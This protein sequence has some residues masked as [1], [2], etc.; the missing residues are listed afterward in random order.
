VADPTTTTDDP[1][2]SAPSHPSDVGTLGKYRV[3][4]L[5]GKGGMGAV[6]LGY[7]PALERK[8]ALKVML[9]S[10]AARPAARERF[11]REARAAAK[12][13]S[14]FVAP[15]YEVG[16]DGGSPFLAMEYL[17]GRS[18]DEYLREAGRPTIP[19]AVRIARE[20]A[21]GLAAAHDIGM[22]HRDVKP[23]NLWLEAPKG[24]VKLLDFGLVRL[25]QDDA[26]LTSDGQAV[27]TPAFMSPEQARGEKVDLRTDLYSLG[28][29]LYLMLTGRLPFPGTTAFETVVRLTTEDAPPVRSLNPQVPE[30]LAELVHRLLF[31]NPVARPKS[32]REVIAA[33]K[34]TDAPL[35][36][37]VQTE[38]PF[39]GIDEQTETKSAMPG[40]PVLPA[41]SRSPRWWLVTG[42]VIG[43]VTIVGGGVLVWRATRPDSNARRPADSI[44]LVRTDAAA[45]DPGKE[46]PATTPAPGADMPFFN[47]K[48]LAGWT[49]EGPNGWKV[50][51]GQLI[52][53]WP[54]G[55]NRDQMLRLRS[56]RTYRDFEL[57]F[58]FRTHARDGKK[59]TWYGFP[60]VAVR[61]RPAASA[62]DQP[63]G[64]GSRV[65]LG[66]GSY[67]TVG[68]YA[69]PRPDI[70][71][72]VR[73]DRFTD[74]EIRCVGTRIT[75]RIGG[76]VVSDEVLPAL[77]DDGYI[78]WLCGPEVAGV[79]FADI[80]FSDPAKSSL[81][82]ST[83]GPWR[84]LFNG[85]E[86]TGWKA[87]IS[88]GKEELIDDRPALRLK[89][90]GSLQTLE[91]EH[92]FHLTL[93]AQVAADGGSNGHV[94]YRVAG[95]SRGFQAG[96]VAN[97]YA[98]LN[99]WNELNRVTAGE[100]R[101]GRIVPKPN[102][103]PVGSLGPRWV[104]PPP[105]GAW[106]RVD[107]VCLGDNCLHAIDGQP[108]VVA[109]NLTFRGKPVT[110]GRLQIRAYGTEM[111]IRDVKVRAI[112]ELPA[113]FGGPTPGK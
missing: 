86:P 54:T 97:V 3:L 59:S 16:E 9:P 109:A 84:L 80:R 25:Q 34:A 47:G 103:V 102:A 110:D 61:G 106:H 33:L 99:T 56:E 23:A 93:E 13:K 18:L 83:A 53:A 88:G 19:Q 70:D 78:V 28:A 26:T 81:P 96:L 1:L 87:S 111:V 74:A 104:N 10:Q 62:A 105:A 94:A 50:E 30:P 32:A 52:A 4:K 64:Q 89:P 49:T 63:N 27:G 113:A 21:A 44:P 17:R 101:E 68:R 107:I 112:S 24:R 90:D 85:K 66:P 92:D 55:A 65:N 72:L 14:D 75:T 2:L 6:F 67:G 29:V 45:G 41:R 31:K 38:N 77:A 58:R 48:D 57:A 82:P 11:L 60:I 35:T 37:A 42:L 76:T 95:N 20:A 5:L 46:A 15:I 51:N 40:G 69:E 71:R 8:V 7:D 12:V 79:T 22:I 73:S 39:A 98:K 100:V 108:V 43:A 36:V 91:D